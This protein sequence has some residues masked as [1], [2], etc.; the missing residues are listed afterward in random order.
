MKKTAV[1]EQK[2]LHKVSRP[3]WGSRAILITLTVTI[4]GICV[5][6]LSN[7][8][9]LRQAV[10]EKTKA[11]VEEVSVQLASDIDY[12]L[13]K[14]QMDLEMLKDSIKQ[15]DRHSQKEAMENFLQR[16]TAILDFTNLILIY[17]D[18]EVLSAGGVPEEVLQAQGIQDARLGKYGVSFLENQE[19]LYSIPVYENGTI[20]G[21]LAGLRSK[22]NMQ[23]L[24]QPRS[25]SG[26]G[27]SCI[28]DQKGEVI[29]SP[30][31]LDPF[32]H[33]EDIFRQGDTEAASAILEMQS[34]MQENKGGTFFLTAAD[35]S[36]LVL[37]YN[38]LPSYDWVLL[39][40]VP[41]NLISHDTDH[42]V[43]QM[44]I[45]VFGIICLF[46]LILW[47]SFHLHKRYYRRLEKVAFTDPVTGG[48]NNAAFQ[49][50]CREL[51]S[52]AKPGSYTVLLLN[53]RNFKLINETFGSR[54]GDRTLRH[55]MGILKEE[56]GE[57]EAAAR[58]D[59]DV[60]YLCL[61][62]NRQEVLQSR[63]DAVR[64]KI[65]AFNQG[66]KDP[67]YLTVNAGAYV[68][69]DP[70]LEITLAQDRA[71]TAYQS[72]TSRQENV[73][74]FYDAAFTQKLKEE[75]NL[76]NLFRESLAKRFFKVYLQPKVY[77]ENGKTAG[78]E[79]LIRWEHPERGT[80]YP[81]EFI[82]LFERNGKIARWTCLC[83]R[84]CAGCS[85]DGKKEECLAARYR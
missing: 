25:F 54:E 83:L 81:S 58:G 40:L 71:Q 80:I 27:L 32:L 64:E 20:T 56:V 52:Q 43:A 45:I 47:L 3:A 61:Q 50:K 26:Q 24:I 36:N 13:S 12:R 60:F 31:E 1:G 2:N 15:F 10:D 63:L 44:Y 33:L 78:A 39:T 73:C 23:D 82:P 69:E 8:D 49:L 37:S 66:K 67:Y 59:A 68:V 4:V 41:S 11:Y 76:N 14:I 77:P 55:V 17:K 85:T 42:F 29:V 79:A 62:E 6:M 35:S 28:V 70:E 9:G 7:T 74:V 16:K 38:P 34:N 51:I 84:K 65:N 72:R 18:G 46:A 21:V 5:W 22:E 75:R 53:L 19:I 57:K 48:M 30:T